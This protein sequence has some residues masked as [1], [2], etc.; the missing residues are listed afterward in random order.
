M[1]LPYTRSSLEG[2]SCVL[3]IQS[4]KSMPPCLHCC[5]PFC[6]CRAISCRLMTC[7]NLRI[8]FFFVTLLKNMEQLCDFSFGEPSYQPDHR[9]VAQVADLLD[10]RDIQVMGC[11]CAGWRDVLDRSIVRMC[12]TWAG[13]NRQHGN[14]SLPI[15]LLSTPACLEHTMH[16][17][18]SVLMCH[19]STRCSLPLPLVSHKVALP[20][21][22]AY[23]F[24]KIA[25]SG[26]PG[27]SMV[28]CVFHRLI[29]WC[30]VQRCCSGSWNL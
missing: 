13:H 1:G 21:A 19:V 11:A 15:L 3:L 29:G 25:L 30:E 23:Q 7:C 12:F 16:F 18:L 4:C 22:T 5:C 2:C 6:T 8:I 10:D 24:A 28:A 27:G 20:N 14:V 17:L 26:G 9:S